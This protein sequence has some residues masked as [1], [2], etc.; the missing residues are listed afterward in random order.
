MTAF[1][2]SPILSAA[3]VNPAGRPH[4]S[5]I[6]HD[7]LPSAPF[8]LSQKERRAPGK[9]GARQIGVAEKRTHLLASQQD[10]GAPLGLAHQDLGPSVLAATVPS[11]A[12]IAAV[13]GDTSCIGAE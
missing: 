1:D 3:L 2:P 10:A 4:I 12:D 13:R 11:Q 5:P 6:W 8:R 9:R 7:L